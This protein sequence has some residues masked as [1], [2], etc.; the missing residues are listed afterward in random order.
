MKGVVVIPTYNERENLEPI[1]M[2]IWRNVPDADIL[3]VDDNSP[4][5]TGSLADA[6][7][8]RYPNRVSVLHRPAK[9]GLGRA[10]V[11]AFLT[12]LNSTYDYVAQ[13]D[14]DFSH[15]PSYLPGMIAKLADYDVVLGSRYISGVS[16][17]NWDFKRLLLSKM[18]SRYVRA[19]TRMPVS[20]ATGG[21]KVWRMSALR[22]LDLE[23]V[24]SQG[25]LFQVEMTWRAFLQRL[26][27]GESPIV[28]YE[29]RLG[30]SKVDVAI[31]SEAALGVLKLR[32]KTRRSE[33]RNMGDH[34]QPAK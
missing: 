18:A 4:D 22:A 28:F 14:A 3:V 8:T 26:R 20:D 29:R 19:V 30:Q 31:I 9:E 33:V 34:L 24:F 13:M 5:G 25:Y 6:L 16:V 32:W 12:L 21:F 1:I 23:H 11:H 10:Y 17:V 2:A 7:N 15:D 27:V